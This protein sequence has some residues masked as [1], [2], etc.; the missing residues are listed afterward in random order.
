MPHGA[1]EGLEVLI[2]LPLV[3]ECWDGFSFTSVWF[4]VVLAIK[5]DS[6]SASPALYQKIY[7]PGHF[8]CVR[9]SECHVPVPRL[10]M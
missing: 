4:Y 10:P 3:L 7:I 1:E 9:T 2:T 6:V 8:C 5:L